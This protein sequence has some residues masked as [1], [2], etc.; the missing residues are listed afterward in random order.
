MAIAS[1]HGAGAHEVIVVD[2]GSTDQSVSIANEAATRVLCTSKGRAIQQNAGA[3]VATGDVLLF[4]H[5]DCRLDSGCISECLEQLEASTVVVGGCYQQRVDGR[6]LK[7]RA[8]EKGNAWRVRCLKWAY[9]DQGIFVR[10]D[11]FRE[12]GG[13]PNFKLMEDLYFMKLLKRRGRIALLHSPITVSARRWQR[14]GL[15]AQTMRNWALITAAHLIRS[16]DRLARFYPND[17]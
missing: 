9:G 11:V 7:Y 10:A 12:L 8:M 14:R 5:A 17:R 16:P 6:G 2:G 3:A 13:F 4:L 15:F 1:A